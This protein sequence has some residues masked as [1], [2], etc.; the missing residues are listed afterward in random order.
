MMVHHGHRY[1][2]QPHF[3][4]DQDGVIRYVEYVP[5]IGQFPDYDAALTA[6]RAL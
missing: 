5:Q 3:V 4:V 1:P 6:L 2:G